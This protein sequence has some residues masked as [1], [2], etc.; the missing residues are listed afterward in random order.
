MMLAWLS[1]SLDDVVFGG[2]DGG[3]GAGVGGEAGLENDAGFHILE[4]GDPLFEL[5]VDAHGTGDGAYGAGADTNLRT[6]SRA[7]SRKLGMG[8]EAEVVIGCQVYDLLAIELGFSGTGRFQ[9]AEALKGALGT[10]LFQ[11]IVEDKKAG[12]D[13]EIL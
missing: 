2:E 5:H 3:D 8:G 7:A 10:P 9:D 11:L 1:S 4:G 12:F 6:A 13:M